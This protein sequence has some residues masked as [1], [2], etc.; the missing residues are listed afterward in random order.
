[1]VMPSA[2][3]MLRHAMELPALD[4]SSR[5]F[6]IV[7]GE[8]PPGRVGALW[9]S[10]RLATGLRLAGV[11]LVGQGLARLVVFELLP[12]PIDAMLAPLSLGAFPR[13]RSRRRTPQ[14]IG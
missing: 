9:A 2:G 6:F 13:S 8:Q 14:L 12:Q 4:W 11:E 1:M 3:T 10:W 5:Y 7:V